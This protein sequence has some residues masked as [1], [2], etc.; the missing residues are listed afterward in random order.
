MRCFN[1]DILWSPLCMHY[2]RRG[3]NNFLIAKEGLNWYILIL[4]LDF[5]FMQITF[6]QKLEDKIMEKIILF[7][8]F[9]K[10]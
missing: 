10:L 7:K 3:Q 2:H 4:I 8:L 9:I 6:E 5:Y 1:G